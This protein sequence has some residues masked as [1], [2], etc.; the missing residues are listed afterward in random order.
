M[1]GRA[2][3]TLAAAVASLATLGHAFKVPSDGATYGSALRAASSAFDEHNVPEAALSAEHLLTQAAG[4]G[5]NRAALLLRRDDT[6]PAEV[7]HA[8]E[9]M[10]ARRLAREPV[11]YILGEWDFL[12]LTL[13]LRPPVLIPRPET[14]ELVEHVLRTHSQG[15]HAN[16]QPVRFLDVGCGSGAIGV[17]LLHRLP[18]ARCVGIDVSAD[19]SALAMENA[20]RCGVATRYEAALVSGGIA[21]YA[22]AASRGSFDIIVSNPPYIPRADMALIE[23]EVVAYEDDG[24]LCGGT[25]GLDVVRDILRAAPILLDP[26]GPRSIWMEVDTSHPPLIEAWISAAAQASLGLELVRWLPDLYERPRF[27]ELRWRGP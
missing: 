22:A 12:E 23:P 24:A 13:A 15:A 21:A 17:A 3:R 2:R 14:E 26:Q 19:A 16:S 1:R 10:C 25:D 11:Q 6:L 18:S 9:S 4:F 20:A 7:K 5:S 8:F 27:V